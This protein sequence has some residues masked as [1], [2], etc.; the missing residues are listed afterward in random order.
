MSSSTEWYGMPSG[1]KYPLPGFVMS[2]Y[3]LR[4]HWSYPVAAAAAVTPTEAFPS[5]GADAVMVE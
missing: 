3:R 2:S 5:P 1:L 4:N